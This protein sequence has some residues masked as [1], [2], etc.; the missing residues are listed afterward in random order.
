M[1][2]MGVFEHGQE[3]V[4]VICLLA[5]FLVEDGRSWSITVDHFFLSC[6]FMSSRSDSADQTSANS[7]SD[8]ALSHIEVQYS[9][10]AFCAT[11][12]FI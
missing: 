1:C 7:M 8:C 11:K 10:F 6:F 9:V 3:F 5:N 2:F 12:L 4:G